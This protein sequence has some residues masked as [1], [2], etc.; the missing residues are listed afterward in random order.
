M[1]VLIMA[2]ERIANLEADS[3]RTR[4]TVEQHSALLAG[5]AAKM[6]GMN[7]SLQE[8]TTALHKH[9]EVLNEYSG[10][11]KALHWIVTSAI[12]LGAY[13]FGTGGKT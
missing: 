5:I 2:D 3:R 8:N 1:A 13:L 12:A 6:D 10:A 11:R 7:K 9:A 4:E